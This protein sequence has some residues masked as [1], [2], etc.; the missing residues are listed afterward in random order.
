MAKTKA[1]SERDQRIAAKILTAFMFTKTMDDV[2][3]VWKEIYEKYDKK[4]VRR[5]TPTECARLQGMPSH[6]CEDVPHKDTPECELWGN[7]M[8]FP[9]VLFVFEGVR[10]VLLERELGQILGGGDSS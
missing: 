1:P 10:K 3:K 8:A 4:R 7:G 2:M 9:C 6:W 5:L